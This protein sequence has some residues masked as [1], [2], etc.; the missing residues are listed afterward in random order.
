MTGKLLSTVLLGALLAACPKPAETPRK[1]DPPPAGGAATSDTRLPASTVIATWSG[2]QLTYGELLEKK[3]STF[4][5]LKSKYYQ[6]LHTTEQRELE[7][8]VV[9]MLVKKAA[10]AKGQSDEDYMKAIAGDPTVTEQQI[11]EFYEKN[12]KSSPQAPP[13]EAI[14]DRIRQYLQ[15][16]GQQEKMKAEIDR[17]KTEAQLTVTLPAPESSL[18][19]FDLNGRPMKGNKDAKV[20]IVEF[21]DFQCPYCSRATPAVEALL[22]AYPNDVKVYFL[23]YPLSFHEKAMPAAIATEC[24]NRQNKFWELHDK[25]FADQGNLSDEQ[26]AKFAA[27]LGLDVPK[28]TEC[29]KDPAVKAM[30]SADMQ[31]GEEA[32]VQ[33]TP[34]FFI[35]GVQYSQGVPTVEAVKPFVDKK[36]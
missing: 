12:V 1:D 29:L 22:K 11:A 28:W 25:I 20:T 17:L 21:S 34:S 19:K 18:A 15:M 35:N 14:R 4:S 24:A 3:S 36:G 6:D 27:E 10:A 31:Q 30:V 8:V 23:H 32:G 7:G 16:S 33:G 2:G 13:L 26:T 9:E 5:K